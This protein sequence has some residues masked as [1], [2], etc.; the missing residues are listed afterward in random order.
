MPDDP[1]PS[2]DD[3]LPDVSPDERR[4]L[5]TGLL[6]GVSRAFYLTLRVL[7]AGLREPV[8]LAYL[9]ARAADTVADTRLLPPPARLEHL[10]SFRKQVEGPASAGALR[11]IE[12]A[13]TEK[14]SIPDE[15]VL[16][17]SLPQAFALLEALPQDD[18]AK[19]RDVVVTLTRGMEMDL[20]TFPADARDAA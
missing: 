12:A 16:L 2:G 11:A 6:R 4:R 20:R 3:R 9:L 10:L 15:R 18:L 5:L 13:L 14:Q 1:K 17:Q 7:P 19:V 8:G